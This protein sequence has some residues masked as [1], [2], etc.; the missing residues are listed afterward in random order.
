MSCV[1]CAMVPQSMFTLWYFQIAALMSRRLGSLRILRR[2]SVRRKT[3]VLKSE[4]SDHQLECYRHRQ[5]YG[6]VRWRGACKRGD[7][8]Y[9]I[10]TVL[11]VENKNHKL[12]LKETYAIKNSKWSILPASNPIFQW[13]CSRRDC[14]GSLS[15]TQRNWTVCYYYYYISWSCGR[16]VL[17]R[18]IDFLFALVLL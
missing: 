3:Y 1:G 12:F 7:K 10:T 2:S 16:L 9:P 11:Q 17:G 14:S 4:I 15:W 5:L 18:P 13:A 8:V 6:R